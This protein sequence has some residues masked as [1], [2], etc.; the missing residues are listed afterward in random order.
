MDSAGQLS[1]F[2]VCVSVGIVGGFLY[3]LCSLLALPKAEKLR[4]PLRFVADVAFFALFAAVCIAVANV[5]C[6][7][8]FREYYYLG[9]AVGMILY[10]KT[11]HKAVAF[12]K[13]ICYN[14]IKKLVNC[15]K[16][17]KSFRKKEEK[18]S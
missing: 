13:K 8:D 16:N 5:L 3:E 18:R 9:Y 12:F 10:L 7:P 15:V 6:F 17:G 1:R 2:F 4:K 14:S 11:F